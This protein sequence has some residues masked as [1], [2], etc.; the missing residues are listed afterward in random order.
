M[1]TL[2]LFYR[3]VHR[4][5]HLAHPQ[6]FGFARGSHLVPAVVDEFGPACRHLPIEADYIIK[7]SDTSAR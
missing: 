1:T 5:W 7:I 2:P 3:A 4:T 6:R